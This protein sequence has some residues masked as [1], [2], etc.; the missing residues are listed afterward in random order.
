MGQV[1]GVLRVGECVQWTSKNILYEVTS[2]LHQPDAAIEITN[3]AIKAGDRRLKI[4]VQ[5][6]RSEQLK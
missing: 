5:P 4:S 3:S 1:A 2:T 6:Q